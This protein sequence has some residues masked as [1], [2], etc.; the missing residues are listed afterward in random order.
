MNKLTI[1]DTVEWFDREIKLN[2]NNGGCSHRRGIYEQIRTHLLNRQANTL[3][4]D[5]LPDG[6]IFYS[7]DAV[8]DGTFYADIMS[9]V[10]GGQ[11]PPFESKTA[12]GATPSEALR[13]AI[14]KAKEIKS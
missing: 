7:L 14:A 2:I 6:W 11:G 12:Y 9:S 1:D 4:L 3:P 10:V 13:N 5:E 8:Y